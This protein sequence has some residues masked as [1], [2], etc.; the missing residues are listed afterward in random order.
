MVYCKISEYLKYFRS[1][2][3]FLPSDG[4]FALGLTWKIYQIISYDVL[5]HRTHEVDKHN[6]RC[7]G[8]VQD[9]MRTSQI[10]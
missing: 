7:S 1:S 2:L 4:T 3:N 6:I 10:D 8:D 5:A 9:V